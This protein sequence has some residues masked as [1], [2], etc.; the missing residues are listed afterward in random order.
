MKA[1][2]LDNLRELRSMTTD[3]LNIDVLRNGISTGWGGTMTDMSADFYSVLFS[4]VADGIIVPG[5]SLGPGFGNEARRHFPYFSLT[6][7]GRKVLDP[8]ENPVTPHDAE[9]YIADAKRRMPDA[10]DTIVEY[11]VEANQSFQD[12]RY[13]SST[14]MLGISGEAVMEWT[15]DAYMAHLPPDRLESFRK[16]FEQTRLRTERRFTAFRNALDYHN[17]EFPPDLW[18][19]VQTYLD[20]LVAIVKVNRD[21]VAHR[22]AKRVDKQ[23][24]LGNL[25]I[26]LTLLTVANDLGSA[27]RGKACSAWKGGAPT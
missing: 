6:S 20:S 8:K 27:L 3:A 14:V 1:V 18:Y 13:L 26:F 9:G 16:S 12:R 2:V 7:Y 21:D 15:Y 24:A 4:L 22:R 25:T 10:D 19:Q 5:N 23:L 11:L 17:D